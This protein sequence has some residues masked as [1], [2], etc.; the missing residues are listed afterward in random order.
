MAPLRSILLLLV[1]ASSFLICFTES[2]RKKFSGKQSDQETVIKLGHSV[3]SN[4]IDPSRVVQLSWQ[5]R[6]F[7]YEGFLSVEECDHLISLVHGR[8]KEDLGNNGNSEHV[9][10]NRLLMSSKMHLNIEDDVVSR[11]EDRISAWTFL[12]KENSR[13]LQV[14]H[15]GLEKVDRNYNFFG[16]RDLLG[17]TEPLMAIIVLYLSNVTQGGEILFPESKLKSRIRSDCTGSSIPRPIKGNAILFFT[18][19]PNASP[20]KSSFHARCPVLEGEMWHATKFFHIRS[21]SGE[22]V[23]PESD[24][25]DD[26][27]C[28]DEDENCPR[29]A[30]IG[31]CQRNPVFMIGSPDYYGTCR[32][33][34]NAC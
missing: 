28:I 31:E 26:T 25:S 10:T 12:P 5:P 34:C 21:I 3:D 11:I 20:D 24:G 7:L 27:G 19:H 4:R 22:K 6:V 18:L 2:S 30:A 15:Y 17:L 32:K 16:N 29:W 33:S 8:K 13:P 14:M 1:F 9:V 23:S